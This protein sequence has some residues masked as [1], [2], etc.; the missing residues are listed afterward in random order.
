MAHDGDT[1]KHKSSKRGYLMFVDNHPVLIDH[2]CSDKASAIWALRDELAYQRGT[3]SD[4]IGFGRIKALEMVDGRVSASELIEMV[5]HEQQERRTILKRRI[6]IAIGVA[7][8]LLVVAYLA[9]GK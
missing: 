5:E 1:A 8:W 7:A 6:W 4:Q 3:T 2:T 9:Y